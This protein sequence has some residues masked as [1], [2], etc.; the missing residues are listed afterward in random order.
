MSERLRARASRCLAFASVA[1]LVQ[2]RNNCHE[3]CAIIRRFA[4][5]EWEPCAMDN[6]VAV[7]AE[8]EPPPAAL[9]PVPD[10]LAARRARERERRAEAG[11]VAALVQ[12]MLRTHS[13]DQ[14]G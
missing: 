10:E 9:M 6:D 1:I 2:T 12:S 8:L 13:D 3:S 11:R 5:H 7:P 14:A 4:H